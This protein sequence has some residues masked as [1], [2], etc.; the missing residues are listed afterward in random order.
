[1]NA[2][3]TTVCVAYIAFFL[4]TN[5]PILQLVNRVEP[6]VGPFPLLLFWMLF[7]SIGIGVLHLLYGM[8]S[9]RDPKIPAREPIA[10]EEA[11]D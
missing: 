9:V 3:R 4:A 10:T 1:M 5:W 11:G 6:R 2:L 8:L 7:W